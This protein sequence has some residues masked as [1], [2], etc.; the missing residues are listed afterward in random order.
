MRG[1]RG[2][3]YQRAAQ[4]RRHRLPHRHRCEIISPTR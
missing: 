4:Q 3:R 2:E 1:R